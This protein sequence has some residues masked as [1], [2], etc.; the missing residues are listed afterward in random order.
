LFIPFSFG[1]E[2]V[3]TPDDFGIGISQKRKLDF[4]PFGKIL[5]DG[6]TIVT[7]GGQL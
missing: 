3:E 1:V 6:W 4:V 7:D 5:Q 2:H